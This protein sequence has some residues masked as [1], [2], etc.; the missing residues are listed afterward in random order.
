MGLLLAMD[1]GSAAPARVVARSGTAEVLRAGDA[2]WVSPELP[3]GIAAG[4]RLRTGSRSSARVELGEGAS[5]ELE[6]PTEL[7]LAEGAPL[8]QSWRLVSG[9]LRGEARGEGIDGLRVDAGGVACWPLAGSFRLEASG[10]GRVIV[11]AWSGR[12]RVRAARGADRYVQGT[13]RRQ[14][15]LAGRSKALSPLPAPAPLGAL[16]EPGRALGAAGSGSAAAIPEL[17]DRLAG[18]P[19]DRDAL[20]A[21]TPRVSALARGYER[22]NGAFRR[23]VS[24]EERA[25]ILRQVYGRKTAA[26]EDEALQ[27]VFSDGQRALER[28]EL[29]T[30]LDRFQLCRILDPKDP[31]M[32]AALRDLLEGQLPRSLEKAAGPGE[33]AGGR[34]LREAARA[35]DRLDW[36]AALPPLRSLA[37]AGARPE[38]V[39]LAAELEARLAMARSRASYESQVSEVLRSGDVTSPKA[40]E[41]LERLLYAAHARSREPWWQRASEGLRRAYAGR[42]LAELLRQASRTY[43]AGDAKASLQTLVKV[44]QRSPGNPQALAL[45]EAMQGSGRTAAPPPKRAAP[46]PSRRL[47]GSPASVSLKDEAQSEAYYQRGLSAYLQGDP[48]RAAAEWRAALGLNPQHPQAAK[49]LARAIKEL[50]GP[51]R[52]EAPR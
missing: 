25:A 38:A 12:V 42:D 21:L 10:S 48:E 27:N 52:R 49:A 14:F 41:S 26:I 47:G 31:W 28:G 11:S 33:P 29:L 4:D 36:A 44:L 43:A 40:L 17:L 5:V 1:L 15:D 30:A 6:G 20:Q 7:A 3:F 8:S 18:D 37:A 24:E 45:L 51:D 16:L 23:P 13:S 50:G 35:L 19:D 9:S 32:R 46:A 34:D 22:A 2:G 39:A